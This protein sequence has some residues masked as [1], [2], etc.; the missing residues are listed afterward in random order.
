MV[1]RTFKEDKYTADSAPSASSRH[2]FQDAASP[3]LAFVHRR[4]NSVFESVSR[5]TSTG[6]S[7]NPLPVQHNPFLSIGTVG[8]QAI[9]KAC[10]QR[11]LI[12]HGALK[13]ATFIAA[14]A[15]R[16]CKVR[17]LRPLGQI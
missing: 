8:R 5:I 10:E 15:E 17:Q 11:N 9:G 16:A 14:K 12:S 2:L 4:E 7:R 6:S 1:V 13:R 3:Q